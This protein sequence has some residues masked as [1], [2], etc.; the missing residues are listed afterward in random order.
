MTVWVLLKTE[1]MGSHEN[2]DVVVSFQRY[3]T[4]EE[5]EDY[6]VD[7]R[8]SASLIE[9]KLSNSTKHP[10]GDYWELKEVNVV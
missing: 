10:Y 2:T 6:E 8:V 4:V 5:V 7:P 3:P 1:D 9:N